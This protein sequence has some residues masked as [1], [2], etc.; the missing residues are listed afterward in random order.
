VNTKCPH[1]DSDNTRRVSVIYQTGTSVGSF[2]G[3]GVSLDGDVGSFGGISASQTLFARNFQ[4]PA[5]PSSNPIGLI[6]LTLGCGFVFASFAYYSGAFDFK[7]SQGWILV[8]VIGVLLLGAAMII[9]IADYDKKNRTHHSAL[10]R[11]AHQ[12]VCLRCGNRFNPETYVELPELSNHLFQKGF[13]DSP[14]VIR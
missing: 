5:R 1:C 9:L 2:G 13:A 7:P 10:K 3:I 4:P 8:A 14:S 6:V 12:W 11:W